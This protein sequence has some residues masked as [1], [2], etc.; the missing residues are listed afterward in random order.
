VHRIP[1][2]VR[3]ILPLAAASQ[4]LLLLPPLLLSLLAALSH[5]DLD[6]AGMMGGQA[7]PQA[8][9]RLDHRITHRRI[10]HV[11]LDIKP[12]TIK[13]DG[14]LKSPQLWRVQPDMSLFH[15]LIDLQFNLVLK[16]ANQLLSPLALVV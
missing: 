4:D 11:Q 2:G 16:Q 8:L 10:G 5:I 3:I 15:L 13:L 1:L 12:V 9:H 6:P 14:Q 7:H